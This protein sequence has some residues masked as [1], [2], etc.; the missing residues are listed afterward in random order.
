MLFLASFLIG[1]GSVSDL[2]MFTLAP[3]VFL[4]AL[5]VNWKDIFLSFVGVMAPFGIFAGIMY[6]VQPEAFLFDFKFT[7]F[8]L[9]G[10]P[11]IAQY[12]YI[13]FNYATLV[14]KDFWWIPTVAGMFLI[15]NKKFKYLLLIL[16]LVPL[17]AL[18]RTAA[19]PGLG[20]Y[21]LIPLFPLMAC[22]VG[23]FLL[24]ALPFV[25]RS[26]QQALEQ[27]IS[28]LAD[29]ITLGSLDKL[30]KPAIFLSNSLLIFVLVLSPLVMTL[31]LGFYQVNTEIISEIDSVLV[32]VSD[33]GHALAYVNGRTGNGD[34][35][36]ASPALAWAIEAQAADFQMALAYQGEETLHF[37]A[38]IPKDRFLYPVNLSR[39]SYVII[40]PI[41]T[42]WAVINMEGVARLASE[43][44]E[45][46]RV[47]V[48]GDIEVYENP[49]R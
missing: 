15:D 10:I 8:R 19:L 28:R 13:A 24:E 25:L 27:Y 9:G 7:F 29:L 45:W 21:Y 2:M 48:A 16:F 22:G 3:A 23:A 37:P 17:F 11:L 40:D 18:G 32:D 6:A 20:Y 49:Y 43:V 33:A 44:R 41:W 39:A 36:L 5:Y 38:N 30:V 14:F 26:T 4:V 42:N 1:I 35:V 34:L 12:P 47:F 31:A 46:P